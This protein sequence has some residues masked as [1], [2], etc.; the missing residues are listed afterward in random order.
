ML[1][2][3]AIGK[4]TPTGASGCKSELCSCTGSVA[5]AEWWGTHHGHSQTH[6][7]QFSFDIVYEHEY[8][9]LFSAKN[10]FT[11]F[12]LVLCLPNRREGMMGHFPRKSMRLIILAIPQ[13]LKW[14][15]EKALGWES[16][17]PESHISNP[18]CNCTWRKI[19]YRLQYFSG[20]QDPRT[21]MQG[22]TDLTHLSSAQGRDP[23]GR[24]PSDHTPDLRCHPAG[25]QSLAFSF[26][27]G[28]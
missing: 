11:I 5:C 14:R 15:G 10:R 27:S 2:H 22:H 23:R 12:L 18:Q 7:L 13:K 19:Q 17:A 21:R 20:P 1:I 4:A 28:G 3:P 24:D 6:S 25:L 8:M 9:L 26:G 16:I